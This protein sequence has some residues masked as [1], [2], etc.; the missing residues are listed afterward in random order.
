M[1]PSD[2]SESLSRA[3]LE[4]SEL[5]ACGPHCNA[6]KN[7]T[8]KPQYP[9]LYSRIGFTHHYQSL[10]P[11]DIPA[12]LAHYWERIGLPFN[13]TPGNEAAASAI[14]RITGGNFEPDARKAGTSGSEGGHAEKG[15]PTGGYLAAWPTLPAP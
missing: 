4:N 15:P 2:L 12:V 7:S 3:P 9:Q 6:P 13:H 11:E 14:T 5:I 8:P 10:D 1:R